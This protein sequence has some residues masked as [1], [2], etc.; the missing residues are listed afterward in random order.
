MSQTPRPVLA[1]TQGDPA[2]IGPEILLKLV[3]EDPDPAAWQ[4][5]L[6]AGGRLVAWKGRSDPAEERDGLAAALATGLEH[7]QTLVVAP[8]PGAEDR[9]LHVY[10][11]VR[12]TPARFPRRA[13]MALKRP[14]T[15]RV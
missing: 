11:K 6:V 5:L 1:L 4:P 9:R 12:P 3:R 13:G 2:G 8:R 14:I 10:R 7:E 15:A